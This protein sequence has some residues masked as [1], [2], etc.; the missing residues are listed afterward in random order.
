MPIDTTRTGAAIAAYRQRMNMSQ[1]GLAGL[2]NVT[3][4][5][6]SKWEKGLALPDTE[7]LL[8]LAKLFGTTM[9][10]LL[11]GVL[12]KA[13]E[14]AEEPAVIP[15]DE[16]G[17]LDFQSVMNMLPFV[18]T[19]AADH[20]FHICA[21][22]ERLDAGALVSIAPF[23]ST[24]MLA[25]YVSAHS[26]KTDRPEVVASLAP[27]LP[28]KAVDEMVLSMEAPIPPHV[29]QMLMPFASTRVVDQMVMGKLGIQTEPAEDH[30]G[31]FSRQLQDKIH[32]KIQRKLSAL[33]DKSAAPKR[34]S[35]RTHMIRM[36]IEKGYY[37][38]LEECFDELDHEAYRLLL[39]E[40]K[41]TGDAKLMTLFCEN[42]GE[43]DAN[44]QFDFAQFLINGKM[45][46]QLAEA[47]EEM[48]EDVQHH[49]LDKAFE[50]NDT[51]LLHLL[52]EHI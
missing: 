16:L 25:D 31:D 38:L 32:A 50:S 18:S 30:P 44:L 6:V 27:F 29:I 39:N 34:E 14:P 23:V 45:Y 46:N 41:E 52:K 8:A 48:D 15:A 43:L 36:A 40:L 1:Q 24:R 17:E 42:A 10:D 20:L 13:P 21:Q 12:P 33:E 19:K 47:I 37:D 35:P 5:A 2:M 22:N 4:Q 28:A 9:E 7:T 26:F 3:H 11:T 51:E 49:L